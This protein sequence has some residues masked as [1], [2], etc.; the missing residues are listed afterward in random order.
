MLGGT[1]CKQ[2][3]SWRGLLIGRSQGQYYHMKY[4]GQFGFMALVVLLTASCA[5]PVAKVTPSSS[6]EFLVPAMLPLRLERVLYE[7]DPPS[8]NLMGD[9][10]SVIVGVIEQKSFDSFVAEHASKEIQWS[11]GPFHI[12][13]VGIGG[14]EYV[15]WLSQWLE[16]AKVTKELRKVVDWESLLRSGSPNRYYRIRYEQREVDSF[17]KRAWKLDCAELWLINLKSRVF[18]HILVNT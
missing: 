3:V 2:P 11:A 13:E 16:A 17:G 10:C 5:G 9:G 18:V 8:G 15:E 7:Y 1:G 12:G 4:L 14:D 6:R